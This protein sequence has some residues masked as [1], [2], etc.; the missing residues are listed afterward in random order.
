MIPG[1]YILHAKFLLNSKQLAFHFFVLG[2][3]PNGQWTHFFTVVPLS[4]S[5]RTAQQT[6]PCIKPKN[7]LQSQTAGECTLLYSGRH[8][9]SK[10]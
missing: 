10:R 7:I 8:Q 9:L 3:N 1:C 5:A 2:N 4:I 6:I